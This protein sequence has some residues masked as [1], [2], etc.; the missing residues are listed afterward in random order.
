[1]RILLFL[2]SVIFLSA[3]SS[4]LKKGNNMMEAEQFDQAVM[5]YE[6]AFNED[7]GDEEIAT[8]LYEARSRL[9]AANLI[10]VRLQRQS[11]QQRA[12]AV[13]LNTSLQNIIDWK[14]IADSGVKATIAEEVLDA[15]KWLNIELKTLGLSESHNRFFYNLKQFKHIVK[16]GLADESIGTFKALMVVYGQKQCRTMKKQLTP[17]SYYLHDV[18]QA[19]CAN[20]EVQSRYALAK[21]TT[22]YLPPNISTKGIKFSRNTGFGHEYFK[23]SILHNVKGHPWFSPYGAK[24][25]KL[26][27][28]GKVSYKKRIT[29]KTF[30]YFY[31]VKEE[32]FEIVKD[33]KD[34]S[35]TL[36]KLVHSKP[37]K[38]KLVFKGLQ[39]T[40]T[41]S[42]SLKLK[43]RLNGKELRASEQFAS[44]DKVSKSHDVYFKKEG[45]RPLSP[46][47]LDKNVW[48]NAMGKQVVQQLKQ[49]LDDLW[50]QSFCEARQPLRNLSISEHAVRCSIFN[51]QHPSVTGWARWQFSL[52]FDELQLLLH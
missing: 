19:Y 11:N 36:R 6:K 20:F 12:A 34:D 1:M 17:Q 13:L 48:K 4:N 30:K 22:R 3:C 16:T 23:D 15:G 45:V 39:I 18:W 50:V 29:P 5:Y 26:S 10:K 24:P 51:S 33:P 41:V 35:K 14:I 37:I 31:K 32:T 28:S 47:L 21:D 25:L 40:E 52:S 8:K 42:H 38:K 49:R 43:G 44:Q 7:P 9:V 2:L 46:N 27:M